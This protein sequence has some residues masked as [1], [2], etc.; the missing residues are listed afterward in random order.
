MIIFGRTSACCY[1]VSSFLGWI[2][3]KDEK[4]YKRLISNRTGRKDDGDYGGIFSSTTI[5]HQVFYKWKDLINYIFTLRYYVWSGRYQAFFA[6]PCI[7]EVGLMFVCGTCS[8]SPIT[9][10]GLYQIK[11]ATVMGH[12]ER[13]S[14]ATSPWYW[15][16]LLESFNTTAGP[17][18]WSSS[19]FIELLFADQ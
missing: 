8:D 1:C 6:W 16:D 10:S 19:A 15:S 11:Y 13:I 7:M 5:S 9:A 4:W 14:A 3:G 12:A 2:K 17:S 18:V